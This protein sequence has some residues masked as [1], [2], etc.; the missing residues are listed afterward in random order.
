MVTKETKTEVENVEVEWCCKVRR[1]MLM[2]N[3]KKF[4]FG[5]EYKKQ[6]SNVLS[7]DGVFYKKYFVIFDLKS[8]I[9]MNY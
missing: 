5:K 2:I 3:L 6:L 4:V 8:I 7:R 1:T 9:M